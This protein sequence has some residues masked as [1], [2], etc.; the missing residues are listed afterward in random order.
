MAET[1]RLQRPQTS[2]QLVLDSSSA[3]AHGKV[4]DELEDL[5]H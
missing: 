1:Q 5:A 3:P 4:L 2:Q